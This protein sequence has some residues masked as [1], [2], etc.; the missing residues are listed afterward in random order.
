MDVRQYLYFS[1]ISSSEKQEI[2][3]IFFILPELDKLDIYYS[4]CAICKPKD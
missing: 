3:S 4:R 2:A 1:N